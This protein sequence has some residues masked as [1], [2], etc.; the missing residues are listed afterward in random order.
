MKNTFR[1]SY[2]NGPLEGS[3]NKIKLINRIA[4]TI[5]ISKL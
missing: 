2:S 5:K 4:I 1:F 3:I